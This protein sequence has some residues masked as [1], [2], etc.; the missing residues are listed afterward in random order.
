[1]KGKGFSV[2]REQ[3]R[4]ARQGAARRHG[5]AGHP[6]ARRRAQHHRRGAQAGGPPARAAARAREPLQLPTYDTGSKVATRKA[7][8]DALKALG[9]ARPDVV[10]AGRR[11][12]QLD[13]CRD[14]RQGLPRPLLRDVHRRAAAGRRRRSACRCAAT[15]PSPRPSPPSSPAPTTSSAW[16]PISRANIRLVR[17]ARRRLHRR[18]RPLADGAG[19]PGDDARGLR[20][21]RALSQRRQPDGAAGGADGRPA[22]ASSTCAPRARRRRCSTAPDEQFPIGGSKVVRQ[23]DARPGD[24]GGARASRCTRRSRPTTAARR[25]HRHSRDRRLLGQADRRGR[26]CMRRRRPPAGASSSVEDHWREGGLGDAVLEAFAGT[27]RSARRRRCRTVVK[28]AVQ[29]HARLRRRR[30]SRSKR[31]ASAPATSC[32]PSSAAQLTDSSPSLSPNG[33]RRCLA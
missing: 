8:G 4:L 5:A 27:E 32:R 24:G 30:R 33:E 18:G 29:Q 19:R 10:G 2:D 14:V 15:C 13:L 9:A 25:G 1:M 22:R 3:G 16:R 20:Q 23:S 17:L 11:G 6:G 28:L 26:R 12:E 7:Y 21:H 31:R